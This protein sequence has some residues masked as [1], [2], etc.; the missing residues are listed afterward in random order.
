MRVLGDALASSSVLIA[1]IAGVGKSRLAA[2][3]IDRI[4]ESG[5]RVGRCVANGSTLTV[6][7]GAMV[8]LLPPWRGRTAD[9]TAVLAMARQHVNKTWRGGAVLV[10]DAHLLDQASA[11]LVQHLVR[12]GEV[13]VL[14]VV[15]SSEEAPE[16]VDALWKENLVERIDL[17]PLSLAETRQ[18][19]EVACRGPVSDQAVSRFYAISSGNTLFLREL[20]LEAQ[21]C[22]E[23]V[24]HDG[25]WWWSGMVRATPRLATIVARHTDRLTPPAR[26]VLEL[27]ALVEP[28]PLVLAEELTSPA[29]VETAERAGVV[30][31]A[32]D[33]TVGL[34][35]PLFGEVM[36]SRM[37]AGVVRRNVRALG[38]AMLADHSRTTPSQLT[39]L[40][41]LH[42]DSGEPASAELF[43][44]GARHAVAGGD[45]ILG[46]RLAR[47]GLEVDPD[48]YAAGF[49]F[50]LA[51]I[52]QGRH[53][54][55]TELLA[56][57]E[58]R[59]PDQGEIAELAYVRMGT[60]FFGGVAPQKDARAVIMQARARLPDRSCRSL[61]DSALAE[62]ALNQSDLAMA[63]ELAQDVLNS[64]EATVEARL[65]AAHMAS[66]GNTLSGH[67]DVGV[68]LAEELWPS[69]VRAAADVPNARGWMLLDRWLGLVHAGALDDALSM[70]DALI[71][72]PASGAPGFDG[73]VA[74]FQGRLHLLAGRPVTAES[75]LRESV[76][77][78]RVEDPRNYRAWALGL[79][80][81]ACALQGRNDDARRASDESERESGRSRRRLFDADRR[82]ATAWVLAAEG[83]LTAARQL[84]E[85]LGAAAVGGGQF[86]FG[87]LAL[88]D[89]MRLG[90]STAIPLLIDAAGCCK[91]DLAEAIAAHACAVRSGD[92]DRLSRAAERLAATGLD[93][94]AAEAHIQASSA[95]HEAGKASSARA[96]S[97]RADVVLASCE[98]IRTPLTSRR[99]VSRARLTPREL[100]IA[101]LAA[102]GASNREIAAQL[103][104]STRTIEGHLLRA[105]SKLGI[106][107][108]RELRD[109]LGPGTSKN[110]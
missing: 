9:P 24:Q 106:S 79:L 54:E 19:L 37:G 30:S 97:A 12:D 107:H 3:L 51:L 55:A 92:A 76:G 102:R 17:Q 1:G 68:Q 88:Y 90:S 18:I 87:M 35:H 81:A 104:T 50:G 62:I 66:L 21:A 4:E 16:A 13:R 99:V 40:A 80:A 28:L 91:G 2:E 7:F 52:A 22:D 20:I 61:L 72:D 85:A 29:D 93:V 71:A 86:A 94:A 63:C 33:G 6:P 69:A 25:V 108:R 41:L 89:A 5:R 84:A 49:S 65:L 82:L 58:G 36:R 101:G 98:G 70:C 10:D 23:L 39:R 60:L 14:I 44:A 59:E 105:Y 74:L 45:S 47:A 109:V 57:L 67:P 48:S 96:A 77:V 26:R 42:L 73:S 31:V 11:T 103:V 15:R 56:G 32:P 38:A 100:E 46:E 95:F 34:V 78:L 83:R 64:T 75:R 110:A 27:V 53:V 8:H 43:T